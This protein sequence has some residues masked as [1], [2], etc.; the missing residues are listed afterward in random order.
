MSEFENRSIVVTGG[1]S[2]IG[3]GVVR[4]L[5]RAGA[6]I[7][8]VDLKSEALSAAYD[9]LLGEGVA[10][11]A[12]T[13]LAQDV[14]ADGAGE[15]M[16]AAG[17]AAFG[18]VDGLVT[19]AGI[20][21]MGPMMELTPATWDRTLSINLKATFFNV[22]AVA[23]TMLAANRKGSIVTFSSTSA[24][25]ARPGN[26][27][28][29]ISKIGVDHLTWSFA[30]QLA[31]AGIRVNAVSP[32]PIETPM[33]HTVEAARSR[34]AGR[35]GAATEATL[36]ALPIGRFGQPDDLAQAVAFL[37]SERSGFITGQVLGVDG[38]WP[39]ANA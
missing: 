23:R 16:V 20:I 15:A 26:A 21:S 19:C 5:S 34:D 36:K 18:G 13:L 9:R 4:H 39:L 12:L 6:R 28:Y 14:A 37:L 31:P 29:G 7:T 3:Y 30:R 8:I 1:A 10:K 25:G 2:G 27:D 32:G 17:E 11:E 22:Q 24:H 38:G 35:P 33:W